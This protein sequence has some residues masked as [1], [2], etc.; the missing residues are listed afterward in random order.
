MNW[1]LNLNLIYKTLDWGKKLFVDFNAGK[2]QLVSFHRSNN[3]GSTYMKMDGSVLEERST[4]KMLGL[5]FSSELDWGSYIVSIAKI[6]PT[7]LE[8]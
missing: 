8:L 5:T 4:F 6:A 3:N 1:L 7:E 2:T